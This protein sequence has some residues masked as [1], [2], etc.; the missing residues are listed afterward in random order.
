MLALVVAMAD[1]NVIGLDG[2]LPWS[3]PDDLRHFQRL[4]MGH[5]VLMGR[6]TYQSIVARNGRPL[7]GRLNIVLSRDPVF[8]THD[9]SMVVRSLDEG[10]AA[11]HGDVLIIG[12]AAVYREA[13]KQMDR[14]YLTEVHG[15]FDGDAFFPFFDWEDW[16]IVSSERHEADQDHAYPFTAHVL[17]RCPGQSRLSGAGGVMV[18]P[19]YARTAR[20]AQDLDEIIAAGVCPFCPR[21]FLWHSEPMLR[22]M[23]RWLI[24]RHAHPYENAR[25]HFL[26]VCIDHKEGYDELTAADQLA[27]GRLVNWAVANFGMEGACVAMRFGATSYTGSTV[28]HLHAHLIQPELGAGNQALPVLFPIG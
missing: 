4:T 5:A 28:R 23:G 26:L 1:G 6:T 25:H 21:T 11:G 16:R 19:R 10:I 9:G 18:D 7:R 15:D 17:D 8:Q 22:K 27:I 13:L 3:L 14:L 2:A 24:T 12:G 20:Y